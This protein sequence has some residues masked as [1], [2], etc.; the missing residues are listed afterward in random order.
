MCVKYEFIVRMHRD[1]GEAIAAI[2]GILYSYPNLRI[3]IGSNRSGFD[4]LG[5]FHQ[6]CA[7]IAE[8]E[9]ICLTSDD[10]VIQ[11][12]WFE[13]LSKA[14]KRAFIKPQFYQLNQSHYENCADNGIVFIP[15]ECWKEY[16]VTTLPPTLDFALHEELVLRQKWP[17]HFLKGVTGIHNRVEDKTLTKERV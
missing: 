11:G 7:A 15:R 6:E 4:S 5:A 8:G 14:P 17:V 13:Q 10:E 12:P 2:P 3:I 9:F 16:G 1:D